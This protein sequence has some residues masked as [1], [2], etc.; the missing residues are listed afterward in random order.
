MDSIHRLLQI[1]DE[2]VTLFE[3]FLALLREEKGQLLKRRDEELHRIAAKMEGVLYR[4]KRIEGLM[5]EEVSS[6]IGGNGPKPNLS[7]LIRRVEE[8]FKGKLKGYQSKLLALGEGIKELIRENTVIINHS[9]E[10]IRNTL[11]FF[12]ESLPVETYGPYEGKGGIH[13]HRK[14]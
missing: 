4:M 3:E 10:N 13:V 9:L 5:E 1:L 11:L 14:G 2:E 12:K 6:L 7:T 8:P